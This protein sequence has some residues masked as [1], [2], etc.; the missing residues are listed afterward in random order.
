MASVLYTPKTT[1]LIKQIGRRVRR[2]NQPPASSEFE[3]Y[4]SVDFEDDIARLLGLLFPFSALSSIR[5][6]SSE[7]KQRDF[8]GLRGA[9]I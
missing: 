1:E 5:I 2:G 7:Q 9:W 8:A 3:P 6:F 4:L